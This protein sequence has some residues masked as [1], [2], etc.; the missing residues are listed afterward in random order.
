MSIICIKDAMVLDAG[1]S[2]NGQQKDIVI[3]NGLISRIGDNIDTNGMEVISGN[4][5]F[6]SP[7]WF[8]MRVNFWDPGF[9][10]KEDLESGCEAAAYGGFTSVALLPETEPQISGKAQVEYIKSKSAKNIVNIYP[11]ASISQKKDEQVLS[12]MQDLCRS[13]AVAFSSGYRAVPDEGFLLR[14]LLYAG[15]I[16]CPLIL[17]PENKSIAG[18]GM[19]NEGLINVQ[20]GLKGIPVLAEE[21]EIQKIISLCRYSRTRI[22]ISGISSALAVD[23]LRNAKEEGLPVTADV[24][25]HQLYFSEE[26][27]LD[28]NTNLKLRPPL[29]SKEDQV[30]LRNAVLEGVID[31]V[32]SNHTPHEDDSKKCEFD[33]AAF[34]ATGI[35]TLFSQFIEVFG[36][37]NLN[38]FLQTTCINPR[39]ILNI[40]VPE[41]NEG[42]SAELTVFDVNSAWKLDE[43]TNKSKSRNNPLW[44]SEL[45]GKAIAIV[46]KGCLKVLN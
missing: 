6:V 42:T 34:G 31:C 33:I 3:E 17:F 13:G 21:I 20:L 39:R 27:L 8:D 41:I 35:Q 2:Y 22:H 45:Q 36:T 37:D 1:S 38:L 24:Y 19:M 7:G 5:L 4:G 40:A 26:D 9:E 46:N 12:E 29:R 15:N 32:V 14:A 44:N 10:Y 43:N 25:M 16:S 11:T 28:F 23:L 18:K 30:A